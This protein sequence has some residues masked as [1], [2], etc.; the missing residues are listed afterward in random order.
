MLL[1]GKEADAIIN[2]LKGIY[3]LKEILKKVFNI[4]ETRVQFSYLT[5]Y[6]KG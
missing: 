5:N 6:N 2:K 1:C 3:L 4:F